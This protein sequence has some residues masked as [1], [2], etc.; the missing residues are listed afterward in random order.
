MSSI[1]K[2]AIIPVSVPFIW[3]AVQ[4]DAPNTLTAL[5]FRRFQPIYLV[6]IPAGF[7]GLV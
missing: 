2:H 4:H 7:P 6:W 1:I 3:L 5:E